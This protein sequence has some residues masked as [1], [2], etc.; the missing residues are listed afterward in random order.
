MAEEVGALVWREARD[1][2]S[3]RVPECLNGSQCLGAQ[4]SFEFGKGLLDRI[5]VGTVG[6]R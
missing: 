6:G 5:Q 1:D 4:E 3:E 2:I